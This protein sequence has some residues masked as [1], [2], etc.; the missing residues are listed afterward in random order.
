MENVDSGQTLDRKR[1]VVTVIGFGRRLVATLL[2][3]F[4]VSFLSFLLAFVIGFVALFLGMF[5]QPDEEPPVEELIVACLVVLAVLYY[6]LF[7]VK[8]K[9]QTLGNSIVGI[10]VIRTDGRAP[11]WGT[12]L[13]RYVGYLVSV[14]VFALGFIW[15]SFD[16][17][18]QGWHD[19]LAST[20]VVFVD[21][22]FDS[23]QDVDFIPS[24]PEKNWLWIVVWVLAALALP[25][26][27]IAAVILL[28]P[29]ITGLIMSFAGR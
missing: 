20:Y 29:A 11:S 12:A 23:G 22:Y 10:K 5:V 15:A 9:G 3:G 4:F 16:R 1:K 19:K 28:G 21:D 8:W 24:D 18:R 6:V 17:Q 13:I 26:G 27:L 14:V 25:V 2:D 7:W